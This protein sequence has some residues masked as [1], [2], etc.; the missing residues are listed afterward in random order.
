MKRKRSVICVGREESEI[1]IYTLRAPTGYTSHQ[2]CWYEMG[3]RQTKC[4]GKL[5]DAKLFAQQKTVC[6]SNGITQ[7]T[8]A[9][10]RDIEVLKS[11]EQRATKFQ[12]TLSA[13]IEEWTSARKRLNGVSLTEAVEFYNRHHRDTRQ[14]MV[15]EIMPLF[16][17]AKRAAKVSA[18]YI[19]SLKHRLG[20]FQKQL[21]AALIGD[22]TTPDIDKFLISQTSGA[23][24]KNAIRRC[25]VTLFTW[26]RDNGYL[27]Q[28]RKTAAERA[29]TFAM[30]DEA[31]AIWTPQE[32][33]KLL[34]NCPHDLFPHLVIG[35]FAGIR[36]AEIARLEWQDVL[37]DQGYIEVKGRKAKTK[38]RRLVPLREN[39]KQWLEPHRRN[40]GL[41]CSSNSFQLTELGGKAGIG[42][43]QNALRHSYASYR[44]AEIQDASRVALELGNSPE[45][46]FKHYRE[47]VTP[48]GAQAWFSIVPE[49]AA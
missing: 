12:L 25:I 19:K 4:F 17:E 32:M 23:N 10:L 21:G 36:S 46:L 18:I 29:M 38:A 20:K 42:W 49:R 24:T 28:E 45:K 48:E 8:P 39:L 47:L 15:D 35:A 37:W 14:I 11:C 7:I 22:I 1:R 33:R 30:V 16:M 6:L 43:R 27:P 9:T 3:R 41:I 40:E 26:A 13:A 2:C 5:P 31:P 34:T 44:L